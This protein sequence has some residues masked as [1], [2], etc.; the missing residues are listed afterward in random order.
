MISQSSKKSICS[1]GSI[2]NLLC[3]VN[4]SN[5]CC[6]DVLA[7]LYLQRGG[8]DSAFIDNF[9]NAVASAKELAFITNIKTKKDLQSKPVQLTT[10]SDVWGLTIRVD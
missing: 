7:F 2:E 10:Y 4:E 8:R 1:P 5:R 6:K 9:P 3:A